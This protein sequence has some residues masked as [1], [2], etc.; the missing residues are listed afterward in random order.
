MTQPSDARNEKGFGSTR[1]MF[2]SGAAGATAMFSIV[3]AHVLGREGKPSPNEKLN[4]AGIGIGGMG[5]SNISACAAENVVALCDVD[6]DYAAKTFGKFPAA[7][8]YTDFRVMLDRHKD[9]D[10]VIVATPD[11]SHAVI[12][13]AAMERG[14]H[15]YVQKPLAHSVSEV[16]AMTEAAHKYRVVTQMGNQGHSGDGVRDLCEWIWSGAIGAVREVHAWTNRPVWPQG[17]EVER[18]KERPAV[19]SSLDWEKWIG[20][21]PFRP[22]HPAY[23]PGNWRAWWDFGTGSLGD[24]GCHI[25]DAPFWALKLKYPISVEGC[26]STYWHDLWKETKPRNETY[27]RSTIVRYKFPAR[28]G[29][30]EVKLTWWDG[31]MMPPRPDE[32]EHGRADG[33]QRRRRSVSRYQGH[34]DVWLLWPEPSTDSGIEDEGIPPTSPG[35]GSHC[36]AVRTVTRG[37]G[38]GPARGANRPVRTL[39]FPARC[40]KPCSWVTLPFAIPTDCCCGTVRE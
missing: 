18:P 33:R 1:R 5:G 13:L 37:I 2:V 35:A 39:T 12:A 36:R 24:L 8:Q 34:S 29:M 10:A 3:P 6:S 4:I 7:K 15:V 21:A 32:L 14:K 27:P 11:H 9:I 19:P 28:E 38:F 25:L 26:I 30:P 17:I 16:R 20:P 22:Y 40:R 23:H 31:G